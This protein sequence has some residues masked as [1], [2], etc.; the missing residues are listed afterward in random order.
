M[1]KQSAFTLI[2]LMI[3]VAIIGIITA[4]ALPSY[5][6]YV[7]KGHRS[8]AQQLMLSISNK[9]EQYLLDAR[10]YTTDPTT[11]GVGQDGWTCV[12]AN[13]S[14][15]Y[16]TVVITIASGPPP[17]YTITATATGSQDVN[18]NEDM[19]LV[20]TGTRTHNGATGW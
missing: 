10:S 4:V 17:T 16:Y 8:D 6:S 12:S 7:R 13:C 19:T 20:S 1:K 15:N 3:V 14:T 11:L 5:A 18:N 9:Q 2:E